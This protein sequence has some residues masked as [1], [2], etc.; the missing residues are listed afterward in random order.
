VRFFVT[1]G[2]GFVGSHLVDALLERGDEVICL[3]RSE[4]KFNRL[5]PDRKPDL[6]KGHLDSPEALRAG[7]ESADIIF[8][9][10]ALTAARS[11]DEFFTINAEATRRLLRTAAEVAPGLKR[12][13]YVSS[14]AAAGPSSRDA[15]K[16]EADDAA[17][18]SDY[19]ASK[20]AAEELVRYCG[21]PWTIVRPPGVYG[22][23]DTSFLTVFKLARLGIV[24]TFASASQQL[25][26]IYVRDLI[27]ALL[28]VASSPASESRAYFACHPQI[29]TSSEVAGVFYRA[30]K[31]MPPDDEARP[32]VVTL[33]SW[34]TRAAMGAWGATANLL[35]RPTI[36]SSDKAAEFLAEAWTCS[37]AAIQHDTGWQ[38]RVDLASGAQETVR[39]YRDQGVL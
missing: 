28:A 16:R 13:V 31:S 23:R 20:L 19:G 26:L 8:H 35:G 33:P 30:I 5:F 6:V 36:I 32:L 11:R 34:L 3:V 7:C 12:F 10:A 38:A 15:P 2:T 21:L 27:R 1:G 18:V 14:Q 22:P 37:P 39:W 4:T 25:S 24:P 17:P 9:A 29:V